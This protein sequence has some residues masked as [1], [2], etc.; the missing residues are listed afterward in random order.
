MG[1]PKNKD[2]IRIT[3][4]TRDGI[5]LVHFEEYPGHRIAGTGPGEGFEVGRAEPREA[6]RR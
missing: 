6:W 1:R 3:T 4:R 5:Q 2:G